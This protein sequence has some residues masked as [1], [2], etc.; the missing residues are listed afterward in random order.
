MVSR[1]ELILRVRIWFLV[2][3]QFFRDGMGPFK[4]VSLNV[5]KCISLF[6]DTLTVLYTDYHF[7]VTYTCLKPDRDQCGDVELVFW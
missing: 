3:S 7:A 2:L 1:A 5:F 6:T 4:I